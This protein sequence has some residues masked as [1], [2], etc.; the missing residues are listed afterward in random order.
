MRQLVAHHADGGVDDIDELRHH[1][2]GREHC[3]GADVV[4][5]AEQE[6]PLAG[7]EEGIE[8]Q[9]PLLATSV[10]VTH[11]GPRRNQVIGGGK[12][13]G[14]GVV[15]EP[16]QAHDPVRHG[17]L[18]GER[19]HRDRARPEAGTTAR[20]GQPPAEQRRQ[21][22]GVD[23]RA[24]GHALDTRVGPRLLDHLLDRLP[25]PRVALGD[26]A[27]PDERG[28]QRGAPGIDRA[29]HT[30]TLDGAVEGIEQISQGADHA[31]RVGLH[32]GERGHVARAEAIIGRRHGRPDQQLVEA[33]A[34]GV[35]S[36]VGRKPERCLVIR[37][38]APSHVGGIG[39]RRR[40][41]EP[42]DVEPELPTDRSPTGERQHRAR[43][44][45]A[46]EQVEEATGRIEQG[47]LATE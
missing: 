28:G 23:D 43:P 38:E 13:A 29:G 16:E 21:V 17:S 42:C 8:H 35:D 45:P 36:Q 14:P 25:L 30:K 1:H 33:V 37:G 32:R 19:R 46:V 41:V 5:R 3:V 20:R 10:T 18:S 34:P 15:V 27:E 4:A 9:R 2:G 11:A 26:L 6:Q 31:D 47:V 24:A 39:P 7:S 40:R 12:A 44:E 22:A